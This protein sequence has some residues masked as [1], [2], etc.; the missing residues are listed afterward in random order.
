MVNMCV[1]SCQS[2]FTSVLVKWQLTAT[3]RDTHLQWRSLCWSWDASML[4]I[5]S[6]GGV[7][8]IYDAVLG[9][10]LCSISPV[11]GEHGKN[12][13]L[14]LK[15]FFGTKCLSTN[16]IYTNDMVALLSV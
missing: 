3:C 16:D 11:S 15:Y 13:L 10:A 9:A 5:A 2:Y 4:A 1:R 12:N 14:F 6:S 8:D 7:V